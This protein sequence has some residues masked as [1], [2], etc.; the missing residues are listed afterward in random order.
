VA[1]ALAARP[2]GVDLVELDALPDWQDVAHD[3]LG[4]TAA[5]ELLALPDHEQTAAFCLAWAELEARGKARGLGIA[6]W[7]ERRAA[8]L[9]G[10]ELVYRALDEGFALAVAVG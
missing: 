2:V 4:P 3:F 8:L 9:A 5:C 7:N 10:T 1:F 6:E